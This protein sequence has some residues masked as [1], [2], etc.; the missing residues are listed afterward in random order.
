[1]PPEGDAP[2]FFESDLGSALANDQDTIELR[3]G[4]LVLDRVEY[5][6]RR[7]DG[8]QLDPGTLSGHPGNEIMTTNDDPIYWCDATVTKSCG[9]SGTPGRENLCE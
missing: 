7:T 1:M 9:V 3:A 4:D 2:L 5:V 8:V 6:A